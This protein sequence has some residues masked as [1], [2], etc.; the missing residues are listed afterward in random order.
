MKINIYSLIII[1]LLVFIIIGYIIPLFKCGFPTDIDSQLSYNPSIN[2]HFECESEPPKLPES[3]KEPEKPKNFDIVIEKLE[4]R[5]PNYDLF[6]TAYVDFIIT[7]TLNR[8]YNI[9]VNWLKNDII[10]DTLF[11]K[12]T[13]QFKTSNELND[14]WVYYPVQIEGNW[15]VNLIINYEWLGKVHS[16][17]NVTNFNVSG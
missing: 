1:F 15:K 7:N 17:N 5:K 10:V 12:S 2:W 11:I 13:D 8:E 14:W 16:K 6:D 4:P 3:P 9:T